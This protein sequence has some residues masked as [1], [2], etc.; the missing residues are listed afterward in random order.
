LVR[1]LAGTGGA[2]SADGPRLEA[3]FASPY[4]LALDSA[5]FLYVADADNN[6]IRKLNSS[7][8][9]VSTLA[10]LAGNPGSAD[11]AGSAARFNYPAGVAVD[12]SG[13]LYVADTYNYTIRK[14]TASGVVSTLGGWPGSSGCADATGSGARFYY[15]FGL[16]SDSAGNI[17]VSDTYNNTIRKGMPACAVV[18]PMLQP[19]RMCGDRCGAGLSGTCGLVM[20]IESSPDLFHW[21]TVGTYVLEG[22]TN[23]FMSPTP[24]QGAQFY[25]GRVK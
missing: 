18:G 4:G 15:P 13:N 23:F 19:P 14:V 3:N 5:G 10:G 16:A 9:D 24:A 12:A 17:Y 8:G 7:G 2:G 22:G 11:A 1:T 21:Q 25:R 20:D 6:T